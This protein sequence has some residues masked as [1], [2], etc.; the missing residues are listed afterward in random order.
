MHVKHMQPMKTSHD[1]QWVNSKR[2]AH[3]EGEIAYGE[4]LSNKETKLDKQLEELKS[5]NEEINKLK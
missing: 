3:F 5:M 4:G 1:A 2:R